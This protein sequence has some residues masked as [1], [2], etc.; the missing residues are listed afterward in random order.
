MLTFSL[1]WFDQFTETKK[2]TIIRK[3]YYVHALTPTETCIMELLVG[4]TDIDSQVCFRSMNSK[5]FL[6]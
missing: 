4:M 1:A 6:K 3:H 2:R 5:L